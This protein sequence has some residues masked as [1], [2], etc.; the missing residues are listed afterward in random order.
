[1]TSLWQADNGQLVITPHPGQ[2]KA[3]RSEKRFIFVVSGSQGGKTSFL[4]L[5]LWR[6]IQRKGPGDYLA[7]TASFPLL[8]LKM[9][10]EFLAY[11]QHTLHLGEWAAADKVFTFHDKKTRV[12]FG[13]ATNPESLES[14][15]AKGAVLDE[16][17]QDQFRLEAWEAIQ[18]RLA[19]HQGRVLGATTPYNL[20]WLKQLVY[21]K[22]RAGDPDFEVIQFASTTNPV[23]PREEFERAQRTLPTWK[24]NMF[25]R[26][27]FDRP[28]GLIYADFIDEYRE[29]GGHKVKPFLIPP[30]WPR[31]VGI[32]FGA[33]NTALIWLAHDPDANVYYLY[34][35]SLEGGKTTK[36]HVA[37]AKAAAA[38]LNM[39]TWHGGAKSE[40]QQRLDWQ[41]E[42][43]YV[44][45]PPVSDVESGIDKVI[46]LFKTF[47]LYV[48]D[49]CLGT[50]DELGTYSRET[51]DMGQ[52]T[53]KIKD[54]ETFHRLDGLRYVALGLGDVTTPFPW[55]QY[56]DVPGCKTLVGKGS[57]TKCSKCGKF[58]CPRHLKAVNTEQMCITCQ[59]A[60]VGS[61]A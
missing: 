24:F 38:G 60:L 52:P 5:W 43:I 4:P 17:G 33:V 45:E 58:Y 50:L 13:S 23:F 59:Q 48:F 46:E 14:A 41:A 31:H 2:A 9:L 25:Y 8:K 15:T 27:Q 18:R 28:A 3:W 54:K 53:E 21:D 1:M 10:P 40:V 16:C 32:D 42:G 22:W 49:D 29:K 36:E 20:G 26:G 35:E 39:R 55:M 56:C 47:T 57:K 37:A 12:I 11:F 61:N 44:Q 30:K 7:V 6:E 51:D 19:L 34:R